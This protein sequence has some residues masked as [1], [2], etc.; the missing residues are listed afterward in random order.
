[1]N[2]K[3]RNLFLAIVL[4]TS[5]RTEK[6][7]VENC[8]LTEAEFSVIKDLRQTRENF[9]PIS[10]MKQKVDSLYD[11]MLKSAASM[12]DDTM[13]IKIVE[14][15]A[16]FYKLLEL[17]SSVYY[18]SYG[19]ASGASEFREGFESNFLQRY[20]IDL[21]FIE[22]QLRGSAEGYLEDKDVN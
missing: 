18:R 14:S 2:M 5:C 8:S 10:T 12:E 3:A 19:Y 22:D 4:L 11:S 21:I 9:R 17:N 15:R 1:M 16:A 6:E 7:Q 13:K 20:Y